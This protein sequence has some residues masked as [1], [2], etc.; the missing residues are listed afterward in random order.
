M[1]LD[2]FLRKAQFKRFEFF[3]L[4][5]HFLQYHL[6]LSNFDDTNFVVDEYNNIG[7]EV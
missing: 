7:E 6:S 3:I 5:Y 2:I 4:K 1:N